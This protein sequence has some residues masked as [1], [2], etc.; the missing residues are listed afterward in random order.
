MDYQFYDI[1]GALGVALV[2]GSYFLVQIGRLSTE[3][4]AYSVANGLGAALIL[5]SLYFE[6]NFSAFLIE[7]FWLVISIIGL[8]R[9]FRRRLAASTV[10]HGS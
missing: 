6:F 1:L 9:Y 2:V 10:R 7:F 8:V 5:Y 3:A 4:W